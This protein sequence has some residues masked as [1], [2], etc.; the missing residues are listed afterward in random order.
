MQASRSVGRRSR[1]S[2]AGRGISAELTEGIR[3]R[4]AVFTTK[5]FM[6]LRSR[7]DDEIALTLALSP[8]DK[9]QGRRWNERGNFGSILPSPALRKGEGFRVWA[10]FEGAYEEHRVLNYLLLNFVS[11]VR[12]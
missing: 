12:S 10:Y 3:G 11:F 1:V 6:S 7:A 5:C 2:Q 9:S 4:T 8:F